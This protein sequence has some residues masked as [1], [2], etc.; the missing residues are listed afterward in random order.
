[1]M[2]CLE[3]EGEGN[4]LWGSE[5]GPRLM[6]EMKWKK[7]HQERSPCKWSCGQRLGDLRPEKG[8]L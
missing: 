7:R 4:H 3:G 8:R 2:L 6:Q 5:K 1:M